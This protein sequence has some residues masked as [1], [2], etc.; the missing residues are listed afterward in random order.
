MNELLDWLKES[1]P[2]VYKQLQT[3][4]E[5]PLDTSI[6]INLLKVDPHT[7][8]PD[9]ARRYGWKY[10]GVPY[11][12]SG[13]WLRE[14]AAAPSATLEH[15]LG[16]YYIQEAASML[17]AEL[18][19]FEALEHPLMLDMA[20]S[21]GGKSIHLADR[22]RDQGFLLANDAS[23]SRLPAL[24]MVLQNWGLIQQA[25]TCQP[26]ETLAVSCADVFDV[27]LLDAP[28][29]MQGLR[30]SASHKTRAITAGEIEELAARQVHL[31]ES[32][33]RAAKPGG[34]LVYS[35]CTLTPQENEGVLDA[36]L[37][38]FAGLVSLQDISRRLP[39]PA[40]GLS[41]FRDHAYLAE[42]NRALR[43]WPHLFGTAGFFAAKLIKTDQ[44][45]PAS[46]SSR[47]P[48][49]RSQNL[50]VPAQSEIRALLASLQDQYGFD[51]AALMRRQALQIVEINGNLTLV[52][53][54]LLEKFNH[55]AWL[56]AGLPLGKALPQGWQPS[57]EFVSRF[58]AQFSNG[59][60]I[61]EEKYL[62]AWLRGE[63]IRGLS[64]LVHQRGHIVVVRDAGGRNL[65][66]GKLLADRLKNM[67]PTR[68]F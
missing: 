13:F 65:G 16:C 36:V 22:S 66:R 47:A 25:V 30:V 9:W 67:L 18:F 46:F 59:I 37:R 33:L 52:S 34:Q 21:P 3:I 58:G 32:A 4:E 20:S 35:T 42:M 23:R 51:L 60:F 10:D 56:S 55:L 14:C 28:C 24:R 17:P 44:L 26:G 54:L 43:L 63:D 45:P 6:R 38:K 57:H 68:I 40:P 12:P 39:K 48:A 2:L 1:Q 27:V 19:D 41:S 5:Q 61:L 62:P 29:S 49:V 31:L 7:A 11:C 50:R 15:R 8:M 53:S 64:A